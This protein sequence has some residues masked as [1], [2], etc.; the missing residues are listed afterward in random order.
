MHHS[1]GGYNKPACI[2]PWNW[3]TCPIGRIHVDFFSLC[4][5]N[6]LLL[7]DSHRVEIEEMKSTTTYHTVE[8]LRKWFS[9]F[10]IP[11]LM[12]SDND[13]QFVSY[14]LQQFLQMNGIKHV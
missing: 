5:K 14:E 11:L 6:Y 4:G 2:H 1:P 10:G 12:V 13:L 8:V 9:Q 7:V 3:P